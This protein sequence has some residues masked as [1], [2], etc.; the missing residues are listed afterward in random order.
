MADDEKAPKDE[1]EWEDEKEDEPNVEWKD[2][3][4]D[5]P[6][7]GRAKRTAKAVGDVA[8]KAGKRFKDWEQAAIKDPTIGWKYLW[9]FAMPVGLVV[10]F[11]WSWWY[12]FLLFLFLILMKWMKKKHA[13]LF[14][15]VLTIGI[16]LLLVLGYFSLR[17]TGLY[18]TIMSEYGPDAGGG[19]GARKNI[20]A[21]VTRWWHCNVVAPGTCIEAKAVGKKG[22][23]FFESLRNAPE[24]PREG[25]SLEVIGDLMVETWSPDPDKAEGPSDEEINVSV[26]AAW[27]DKDYIDN[28]LWDCTTLPPIYP[29]FDFT[30]FYSKGVTKVI[31]AKDMCGT[32]FI[33]MDEDAAGTMFCPV[34][35]N[36]NYDFYTTNYRKLFFSDSSEDIGIA[37][38]F[39]EEKI[40]F[41]TAG[42]VSFTTGSTWYWYEPITPPIGGKRIINVLIEPVLE[43]STAGGVI[44]VFGAK[45]KAELKLAIMEITTRDGLSVECCDGCTRTEG[46]KKVIC[47]KTDF[48]NSVL[49]IK[50]GPEEFTLELGFA[51]DFMGGED[52]VTVDMKGQ[53]YYD[54]TTKK[55]L[56]LP[57]RYKMDEVWTG[58]FTPENHGCGLDTVCISNILKAKGGCANAECIQIDT[59]ESGALVRC[60]CKPVADTWSVWCCNSISCEYK[61]A[62]MDLNMLRAACGEIVS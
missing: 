12:G 25:D 13:K 51:G 22:G 39:D 36:V 47:T 54:M 15:W 49:D 9:L 4:E 59:V 62:S 29:N 61:K 30:C 58:E 55:T 52:E 43:I 21:V 2:D 45:D 34:G 50:S 40:N 35:V 32:D 48:D 20:G 5:K 57:I 46:S 38:R 7:K 16:I 33:H 41:Y 28:S 1:V 42:P 37:S 60:Y 23:M 31:N 53:L 18:Q 17:S 10:V 27:E 3:D 6:K 19:G 14:K 11:F 24:N 26:S 44:E 56:D 8:K